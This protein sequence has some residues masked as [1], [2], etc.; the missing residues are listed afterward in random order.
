MNA[1]LLVLAQ[2][3]HRTFGLSK[4]LLQQNITLHA[5][6][7]S[8][9]PRFLKDLYSSET[10]PQ[11]NKDVNGLKNIAS[12]VDLPTNALHTLKNEQKSLDSIQSNKTPIPHENQASF[13]VSDVVD[14]SEIEN[15]K[16]IK[17]NMPITKKNHLAENIAPN[18]ENIDN[19]DSLK[20]INKTIE[21]NTVISPIIKIEPEKKVSTAEK[22]QYSIS[23]TPK[24]QLVE[25]RI[26]ASRPERILH[27]SALAAGLGAGALTET[28]RRWTGK[29]SDNAG[30]AFFSEQN[31]N[32]LVSKLTKMR[33][34]ALKMG[35][36]LSIQDSSYA[37]KK[38]ED[39]LIR[40]QNSANYMPQK[41]LHKVLEQQL[42]SNWHESFISFNEK[43]FAAASIGQVHEAE[44][45]DDYAKKYGF[46]KVAVKVQYP[47]VVK[48][49]DSDLANIQSLLV[50]S[51][52]LPKGL[53]LDNTIKVAR[54]EL[55]MECDY[56]HE[57]ESCELFH[58]LLK[59]NKKFVIPKIVSELSK[60]MVLTMEHISGD[61]VSLA[62]SYD[63]ETRDMVF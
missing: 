27:Y 20:D 49:I 16:P 4:T 34:A 36:M 35:Q 24:K 8:I 57:A 6:T 32:R 10:L 41:Q 17:K 55:K 42:G 3:V 56:I 18:T 43:P 44:L 59:E 33:G 38:I 14:I 5:N 15:T 7:S 52:L 47:G 13:Q 23:E 54:K 28:F 1:N 29:S 2:A 39:I 25:S 30:S 53:Y 60:S 21:S 9:V 50:I 37:S 11:N 58:N 12:L 19:F 22:I 46:K 51:K 26:P 62:T 45:N 63:Q 40:V 61:P 31:V 48:S